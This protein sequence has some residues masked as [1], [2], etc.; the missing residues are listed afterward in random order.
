M[1]QF[2]GA[3]WQRRVSFPD[4]GSS[5]HPSREIW[6]QVKDMGLWEWLP[7]RSVECTILKGSYLG[8]RNELCNALPVVMIYDLNVELP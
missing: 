3:T 5:L 7:K 8:E 1:D 2:R 6:F 4:L